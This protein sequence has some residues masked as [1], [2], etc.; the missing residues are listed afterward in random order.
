MALNL[1]KLLHRTSGTCFIGNITPPTKEVANLKSAKDQIQK[2]LTTAIPAWLKE[3]LGDDQV[4]IPRFRTQ[5]SQAYG[6]CNSP[7][8][9][10]PQEMDWDFGIY[11]PVS[12]YDD[13]AIHPTVAAKS[14]Y[15]MVEESIAPLAK[16][17]GWTLKRKPTCVRVVLGAQHHAHVDLPLYVAP[18]AELSKIKEIAT[19]KAIAMDSVSFREAAKPVITWDSLKRISLACEDGTWSASDPGRVVLWFERKRDRYGAQLVRLCRYLKAWRDQKWLSGGPSSLLLMVCA[20]QALDRCT[21][22]FSER[23]DL[24][25]RYILAKLGDQLQSSVYENAVNEGEDL[26]RLN[27][28]ERI[29]AATKAKEFYRDLDAAISLSPAAIT[30]A[31]TWLRVHLGERLP[32]DSGCVSSDNGPQN[33]RQTP[34]TRAAAPI[35]TATSAG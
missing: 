7:C 34:P 12:L 17:N 3:R 15:T 31:I 33:I 27:A 32:N 26:N 16:K 18:D 25:L 30:Q 1:N 23:D 22:E 10:P 29:E 2:H 35:V 21:E 19:L 20:V 4:A 11:L 9:K 6:T 5:G 8:N 14:Y 13:N 24:A 28:S